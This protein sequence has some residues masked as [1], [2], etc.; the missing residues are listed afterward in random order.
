M[1]KAVVFLLIFTIIIFTA[2]G[3]IKGKSDSKQEK[4][5]PTAAQV[6]KSKEVKA[7]N[8]ID[9]KSLLDLASD[10][11]EQL[12]LSNDIDIDAELDEI[13]ALLNEEDLLND[14]PSSIELK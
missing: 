13:E 4:A 3:C 14:I 2:T 11:D 9:D 1:K 6:E 12:N 10:G 8:Q 7:P 5:S